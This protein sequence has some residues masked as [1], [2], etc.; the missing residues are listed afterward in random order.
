MTNENIDKILNRI[1]TPSI[2]DQI[3]KEIEPVQIPV[4]Y[5]Q[6]LIVY[7]HDGSVVE[8]KGKDL[9]DP[10]PVNPDSDWSKIDSGF[11][12]IRDVKIMIDLETLEE[13][14]NS[15]VETF[16]GKYC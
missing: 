11:K 16:L 6:Q 3:I 13:D 7:Y 15:R 12:K 10:I 14:I 5:I 9:T 1:T 8:L 4:K 2:F